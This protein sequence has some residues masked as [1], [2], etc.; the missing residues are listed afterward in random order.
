METPAKKFPIDLST[1]LTALAVGFWIWLAYHQF[2]AGIRHINPVPILLGLESCVVGYFLL[3]RKPE[4]SNP[5]PW[6]V[7]L[8]IPAM[9]LMGPLLI[10]V[11]N[12]PNWWVVA[13]STAGLALTLWALVSLGRSFGIAPADRG[14]VTHGPYRYLRHPM[15]AGA[16]LNAAVVVLGNLSAFNLAVL[17]LT[18][19]LDV[20]RILIEEKTVSGYNGYANQVRWR[21]LP[22]IW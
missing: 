20:I 15:Y 2:E 7:R 5:H 16:L 22:F 14:L 11:Y 3:T 10:E 9:A 18:V 13:F 21:L 1:A 12:P 17:A 4:G 8:A 19:V 6:L